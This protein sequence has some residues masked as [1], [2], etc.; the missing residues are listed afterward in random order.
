MGRAFD[1]AAG[2]RRMLARTS[3]RV[4]PLASVL[5]REAQARLAVHLG[6]ALS[7]LG[8]RLVILD[9]SR[10]DIASVLGLKPRY[11]LL[12]MLE[13]EKSFREV[14]IEGPDELRIVPAARGIESMARSDDQGWME[15]FAAFAAL[16]DAPDVILLNCMPRNA[17]AACRAASGSHE[18]VLALDACADSVTAAYG[19]IK[20]ALRDCGQRR[21]RLVFAE[22]Q[23]GDSPEST[24]Q[25]LASRF[26][27]TA[28]RFLGAELRPGGVLARHDA[29]Q[30]ATR[31][32][33]VSSDPA[34]PAAAAFLTLAG[35]SADW[36]L[37]EFFRP[38]PKRCSRA[39]A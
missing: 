26:V 34:H 36:N 24:V 7:H 15:L 18:V 23:P 29:L 30:S 17:N 6:A 22:N 11:E 19:L 33:I 1:Q 39:I 28:R 4:L 27:D 38:M 25:A 3:M 2:L 21:F 14:A 10:G 20:T 8:S 32:T 35:A 31:Q 13:G 16:P 12:H 5:E 37:P 9:G